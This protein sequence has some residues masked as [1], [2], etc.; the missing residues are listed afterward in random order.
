MILL[1]TIY[2]ACIAEMTDI[3]VLP[4]SLLEMQFPALQPLPQN[5]N[6]NLDFYQDAQGIHV[7]RVILRDVNT[8]HL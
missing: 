1:F 2:M 5:L 3:P 4:G 7:H 6:Q 8:R